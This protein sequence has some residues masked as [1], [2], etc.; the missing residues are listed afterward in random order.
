MKRIAT[1][2]TAVVATTNA[3]ATT[4]IIKDLEVQDS[5]VASTST[6]EELC[7][8]TLPGSICLFDGK[9]V[10]MPDAAPKGL[11][12][13]WTFDEIKP[14]DSSGNERHATFTVGAAPGV[15][16]RGASGRFTGF[17]ISDK[18][19]TLLNSEMDGNYGLSFWMYLPQNPTELEQTH[20]SSGDQL[21]CSL[22]TKGENTD[23]PAVSIM[24]SP[25]TRHL[26]IRAVTGKTG[27]QHESFKST[28]KIRT[29][30][31]VHVALLR[32]NRKVSGQDVS[33]FTLWLNGVQDLSGSTKFG[34]SIANAQ[35]FVV[36]SPKNEEAAGACRIMM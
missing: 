3:A 12:G 36:G 24:M 13:R 31:W 1:F 15:M 27:P 16:G 4:R 8:M 34:S 11:S 9:K 2:L 25:K 30:A 17:K 19:S 33:D 6:T 26:E 35:P 18:K 29:N 21:M 20:S 14:V 10:L 7:D 22:V 28:G 5:A 32:T 23:A